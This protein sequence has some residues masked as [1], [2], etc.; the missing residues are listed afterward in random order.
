MEMSGIRATA[1]LGGRPAA[2]DWG[3]LG[4]GDGVGLGASSAIGSLL[5]LVKRDSPQNPIRR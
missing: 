2:G 3:A 1:S 4:A 5:Y